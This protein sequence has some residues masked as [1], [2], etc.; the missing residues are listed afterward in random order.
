M[1]FISIINLIVNLYYPGKN[2]F[3]WQE[4]FLHGKQ[5]TYETCPLFQNI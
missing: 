2:N 4:I 3:V 1:Q 5:W